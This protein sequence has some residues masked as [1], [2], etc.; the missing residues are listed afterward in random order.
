MLAYDQI[1][2]HEE[3]EEKKALMG[4]GKK[5]APTSTRKKG[6]RRRR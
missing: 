4:V 3:L 5:T 1:R 2:Q 6:R